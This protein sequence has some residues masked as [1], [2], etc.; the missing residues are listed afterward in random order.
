MKLMPALITLLSLLVLA[1]A[2][3]AG[4]ITYDAPTKTL[5]VTADNGVA[6]H[7]WLATH[8]A[9]QDC[10]SC[11]TLSADGENLD[12]EASGNNEVFAIAPSAKG[13]CA[14]EPTGYGDFVYGYH[15]ICKHAQVWKVTIFAGDKNDVIK[16]DMP[17]VPI[18]VFGGPGNDTIQQSSSSDT[19]YG[20]EGDDVVTADSTFVAQGPGVD[21]IDGGDGN[22]KIDGGIGDDLIKGDAGDD[23]LNG[24]P[25]ADTVRPGKGV[26]VVSGGPGVDTLSYEDYGSGP[27]TIRLNAKSQVSGWDIDV[28]DGFEDAVGGSGDDAIYGTS[29]PNTLTGGYGDDVLYGSGGNDVLE[30]VWDD[31]DLRGGAGADILKGG[32][33][34]DKLLGGAGADDIHGGNGTDTVLYGKASP[35]PVIV[36]RDDKPNDGRYS[37]KDDVHTDV[38][39]LTGT[40]G[41]DTLAGG[42]GPETLLGYAGDDILSTKGDGGGDSANCGPGTDRYFVDPGDAFVGCE[43]DS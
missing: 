5:K 17:K 34:N 26:D 28:S 43:L 2:A 12:I 20:N 29:G 19:I 14:L 3:Q 40:A 13:V 23:A 35:K 11:G 4:T 25:G 9:K 7:Y 1:P 39:V 21:L 42:P 15:A 38:E 24:G 16:S 27:L 37:E 30:G 33:E 31:D 41:N 8:V 32:G 6:N 10:W 18:T 22:D 36:S